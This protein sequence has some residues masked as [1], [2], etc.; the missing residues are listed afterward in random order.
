MPSQKSNLNEV[1]MLMDCFIAFDVNSSRV[2]GGVT[3]GVN[4]VSPKVI[5]GVPRLK[6]V[7][8][9]SKWKLVLRSPPPR[10]NLN[11]VFTGAEASLYL[12][13]L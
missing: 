12:S 11:E 6:L 10:S 3:L 13:T 4:T 8:I 5:S 7:N 1:L 2:E 9:L